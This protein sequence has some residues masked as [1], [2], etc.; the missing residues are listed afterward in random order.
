ML[1]TKLDKWGKIIN[2][3]MERVKGIIVALLFFAF[4]FW[5]TFKNNAFWIY[6]DAKNYYA[7]SEF[8][9]KTGR[10]S[11][12]S[13]DNSLRGYIWPLILL[14]IRLVAEALGRN[15]LRCFAL[16]S[17]LSHPLSSAFYCQT[18]LRKSSG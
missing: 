1:L 10:F 4:I 15:P 3:K 7:F 13:Y 12:T 8:F 16:S 18:A 2:Q 14:P 11:L 6:N 5:F 17:V 9:I